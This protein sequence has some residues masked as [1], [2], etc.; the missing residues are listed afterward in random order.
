[1][2]RVKNR[3]SL[4][5]TSWVVQY[6]V[7]VKKF[8]SSLDI[9]LV[10]FKTIRG[11]LPCHIIISQKFT[12]IFA[13]SNIFL[14]IISIK[15]DTLSYKSNLSLSLLRKSFV[16]LKVQNYSLLKSMGDVKNVKFSSVRFLDVCV[17]CIRAALSTPP[18]LG[19][20]KVQQ[21]GRGKHLYSQ[22]YSHSL[23]FG[24]AKWKWN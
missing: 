1:M 11:G 20:R 12:G 9:C 5:K 4:C 19:P 14:K 15:T 22:Y 3:L 17:L 10:R 13:M 21:L 2:V 8:L 6:C 16:D 24:S 7:C 18:L 23:F